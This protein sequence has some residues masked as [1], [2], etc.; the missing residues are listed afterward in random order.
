TVVGLAWTG[1]GALH[2]PH[3][4]ARPLSS[5]SRGT[6]LVTPQAGQRIS[7]I[8][9]MTTSVAQG[10][11]ELLRHLH[12][13]LVDIAPCPALAGLVGRDHRMIGGVKVARGMAA[14][15]TV[16]AADVAAAQA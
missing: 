2:L 5:F 7:F 4:G 15:R 16:A 10:R 3:T 14:R 13:R 1:R 6:R 8:S 11:L 9:A 12:L